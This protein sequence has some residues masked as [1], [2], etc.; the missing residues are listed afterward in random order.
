MIKRGMHPLL[1]LTLFLTIRLAISILGL[2]FAPWIGTFC[3]PIALNLP[4]LRSWKGF[5]DGAF[6]V[7]SQLYSAVYVIAGC[8]LHKG[9]G[10]W[11]AK[12]V[13]RECVNVLVAAMVGL[14]F[15]GLVIWERG[16]RM[17]VGYE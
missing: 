3:I 14:V 15:V 17:E 8:D 7:T 11:N 10:F 9:D 5:A 13:V 12:C 4:W 2:P 1:F 6:L 16:K